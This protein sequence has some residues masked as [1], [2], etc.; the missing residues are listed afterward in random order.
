MIVQETY[1]T[2]DGRRLIRRYSDLGVYIHGGNPVGD[3]EDSLDPENAA[4]TFEETDI[5]IESEE[6]SDT[7][8]LAIITGAEGGE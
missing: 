2:Q 7:E 4:V 3:Y 5:P 1:I 8:A 6:I